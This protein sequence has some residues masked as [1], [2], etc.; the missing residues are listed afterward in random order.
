MQDLVAEVFL[1]HTLCEV[2]PVSN[3]EPSNEDG[4]RNGDAASYLWRRKYV[5]CRESNPG[6]QLRICPYTD[7]VTVAN[8]K[9]FDE[10]Y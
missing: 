6:H 8:P 3:E 2:F 7:Y 5:P 9:M 10:K 1:R 4:R